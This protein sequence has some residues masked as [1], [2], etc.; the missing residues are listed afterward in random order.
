M[1]VRSL[2]AIV[3][4][5]FT[6]AVGA[7]EFKAGSI[8][9]GHPYARAT[10]SGQQAGGSFLSLDNAG[11][12]D[13]LLSAVSAVA[14]RVELHAMKMEGD[15]MKM[16]QLDAIDVPAKGKIELKPGG[17]HIMLIG[18]KAPLKEGTNFPLTLRFEKAGEVTVQVNVEA[19]G[20]SHGEMK[21]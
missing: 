1:Q 8:R 11:D 14:D 12:A 9:I 16:R 18:L 4:A 3:C 20:A 19:P 15:V 7:H 17:L 2:V 6:V 21:H 5:F 10:A 13:K